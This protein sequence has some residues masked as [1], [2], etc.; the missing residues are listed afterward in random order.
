VEGG[1]GEVL[2]LTLP[3]DF[4]ETRVM[5]LGL[6]ARAIIVMVQRGGEIIIPRG[7]TVLRPGDMLK[8]FVMAEDAEAVK[9]HFAA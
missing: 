9:K 6:E 1:L 2:R 8:I 3:D 5:D 7:N 4:P